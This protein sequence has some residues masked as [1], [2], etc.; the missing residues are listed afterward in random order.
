MRGMQSGLA[1][2]DVPGF[3]DSLLKK[4]SSAHSP[5]EFLRPGTTSPEVFSSWQKVHFSAGGYWMWVSITS[6]LFGV[7]F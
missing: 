1:D 3:D 4:G 7:S 6:T 2:F 5:M